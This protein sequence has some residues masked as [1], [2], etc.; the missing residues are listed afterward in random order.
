MHR[1]KFPLAVCLVVVSL[2]GC[3]SDPIPEPDTPPVDPPVGR[4]DPLP[5]GGALPADALPFAASEASFTTREG[6]VREVTTAPTE[7]GMR[8]TITSEGTLLGNLDWRREGAGILLSDGP[9]RWVE[10][11]RVGA[12]PGATWVSSGRTIRFDGWE[13]VKTPAGQFDAVRVTT[14]SVTKDLEE[15]ETW[16]FAPGTGL[17]RLTQNKGDLFRTEMLRTR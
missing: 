7:I 3:A 8:M 6:E 15:S 10:M 17:V 11:L 14:S 1:S 5:V 9:D 2:V 4:E 12:E 16:W 13:R